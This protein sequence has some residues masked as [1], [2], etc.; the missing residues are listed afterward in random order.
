[1]EDTLLAKIRQLNSLDQ[2]RASQILSSIPRI[3]EAM[4]S[5]VGP[6]DSVIA[7]TA[8]MATV[9]ALAESR[10]PEEHSAELT[11]EF[12]VDALLARKKKK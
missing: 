2:H 4:M 10:V 8:A 12:V 9:F 3:I 5:C 7:L 1:M 6:D 11:F